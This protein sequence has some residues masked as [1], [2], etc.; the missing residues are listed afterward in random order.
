MNPQEKTLRHDEESRV[1]EFIY[2]NKH[3]WTHSEQQKFI[4]YTMA[5]SNS[6]TLEHT[7]RKTFAQL[8]CP[9]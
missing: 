8:D 5:H 7:M 1:I 6:T 9:Q 2:K 3:K 4:E